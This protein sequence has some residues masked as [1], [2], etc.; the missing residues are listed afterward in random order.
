[1]LFAFSL[2]AA[3]PLT[4]ASLNCTPPPNT[5]YALDSTLT[6]NASLPFQD[7]TLS[8]KFHS[9]DIAAR[10]AEL[11]VANTDYRLFY[12]PRA[13]RLCVE[14]PLGSVSLN[15]LPG[16]LLSLQLSATHAS[17]NF[18]SLLFNSTHLHCPGALN[19]TATYFHQTLAEVAI[20]TTL[21]ASLHNELQEYA[22]L[23]HESCASGGPTACAECL[24]G[25]EL[26]AGECGKRA[27]TQK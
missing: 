26:V 22:L 4:L 15:A 6:L 24:D 17:V 13:S 12:F 27:L 23:P 2:L 19:L 9:V 21:A 16:S 7:D 3:F 20:E 18:A 10:I 14:S 25:F 1:M 5:V 8:F 11:T